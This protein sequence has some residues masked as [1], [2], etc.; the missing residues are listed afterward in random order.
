MEVIQACFIIIDIAAITQGVGGGEAC[1]VSGYSMTLIVFYGNQRSPRVIVIGIY[2][3]AILADNFNDITLNVLDVVI[4]DIVSRERNR[5]VVAVIVE[6]QRI[7]ALYHRNQVVIGIIVIMSI[8]LLCTH[9]VDVVLPVSAPAKQKT[10]PA[11]CLINF[12]HF[13]IIL[14]QLKLTKKPIGTVNTL[15]IADDIILFLCVRF[16]SFKVT[17]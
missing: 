3:A 2:Q 16:K 17:K 10:L 8:A 9:T 12:F 11:I 6:M 5:A 15:T 14:C 1:A 7:I 13:K 4:H